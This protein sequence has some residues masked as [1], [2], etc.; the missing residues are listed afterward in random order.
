LKDLLLLLLLPLPLPLLLNTWLALASI[1]LIRAITAPEIASP[2]II[3]IGRRD[4]WLLHGSRQ[5]RRGLL[6][7]IQIGRADRRRYR[8]N[9]H[10][11]RQL[12]RHVW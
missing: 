11:C 2:I 7:R 5:L 12:R 4:L 6:L 9:L 10:T 3:L 1:T 8:G